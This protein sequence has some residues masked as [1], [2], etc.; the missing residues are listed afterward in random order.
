LHSFDSKQ[1]VLEDGG[2]PFVVRQLTAAARAE[3][4][5]A[6]GAADQRGRNP[7]LPYDE[8][9]FV[10]DLSA[11]HLVLLNKFNLL[12]HHL[13]IVTREFK[14]QETLLDP[15]DFAA[16]RACLAEVDGLVFY[17]GGSIAGASQ[18]HKHLQLVPLPLDSGAFPTP[19][20]AVIEKAADGGEVFAA[21]GLAFRHALTRLTP[22]AFDKAFDA[23]AFVALHEALLAHIGVHAV[24]RDGARYQSAPWNLLITR[25]WM[26]AVPRTRA[27]FRG[28][29]INAIGFAGSLY[30]RDDAQL[31][32]VRRFGPMR[33][34]SEVTRD[35]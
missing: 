10:A 24:D 27:D 34:L 9:V 7:F 29:Q 13:L 22:G 6:R 19:I 32:T 15:N 33:V 28:V 35:E 18:P 20:D 25:R 8:N 30:V 5:A 21:P 2:V 23:G 16:L 12:P 14:P 31:G 26:L 3:F 1:Y 11:T 4:Q 17:N